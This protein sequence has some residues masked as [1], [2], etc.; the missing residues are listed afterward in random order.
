M[1]VSVCT[2][3]LVTPD[4]SQ[5]YKEKYFNRPLP[6]VR[7]DDPPPIP[8]SSKLPPALISR[9]PVARRPVPRHPRRSA[10]FYGSSHPVST[11]SSYLDSISIARRVIYAQQ[12]IVP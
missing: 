8:A 4:L 1:T 11:H 6:M 3:V 9:P 5:I 7:V 12:V 2:N 10:L